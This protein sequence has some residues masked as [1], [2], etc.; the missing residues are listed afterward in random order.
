MGTIGKIIMILII[1]GFFAGMEIAFVSSNKLKIELKRKQGSWINTILSKFVKTPSLFIGSTLVGINICLTIYG[2]YITDILDPFIQTYLPFIANN[3]LLKLL[4]H[5]FISTLIVL[6]LSEFLPKVLFRI[7]PNSILEFF[8]LP[9]LV[10][11]Y[12]LYP[13]VRFFVMISQNILHLFHI[14]TEKKELVFTRHDLQSLVQENISN[15]QADQE[16]DKEMFEKALYLHD[17]R[18]RECLIPRTEIVAMDINDGIE[19]LRKLFIKSNFSKIIIY[20]KTIDNIL[21][22]VHNQKML[23]TP[24]DIHSI[25]MP[26]VTVP[27]SMAATDLMNKFIKE[28]KSIAWIINEHGGTAGIVTL[29]DI[30]EEIFGEIEDEHDSD[31]LVHMQ[32]DSQSYIFSARN[33]ISFLN[34]TYNLGLPEGDY[35]TLGGYIFD[36]TQEIPAPKEKIIIGSYE[37][38]ILTATKSR[39]ETVRLIN[40]KKDDQ[41]L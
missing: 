40:K 35:E 36:N 13:I 26:I 23:N 29:E 25:L 11:Y 9:F 12:L 17:I 38:E 14:K 22:Y 3:N 10:F 37:I 41:L 39:I 7:N 28:R 16:I 30:L 15:N 31:D 5:T 19:E 27:E 34:E 20:D 2:I 32:I 8:T 21:G 24:E 4:T 18:L 6:V 1:T 33:E